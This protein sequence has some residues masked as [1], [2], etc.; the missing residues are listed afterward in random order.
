MGSRRAQVKLGLA[1]ALLLPVPVLAEVCDPDR[2]DLR[3]AFGSA[4]FRVE[5]ADDAAERAQGLMFREAM[6]AGAGMLFVYDSPQRPYFWMKNTLIPL[7][8]I[9]VDETGVVTRVHEN[10]VPHDETP[11]DGGPDVRFVLE[12]NGGLAA[13][14]GIAPGDQLR[15]PTITAGV[16]SCAVE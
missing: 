5:V 3:G 9:F 13:R 7:D 6:A 11:I 10:A 8:M 14:L 2:V 15:H 16:W 1:L 12:I 4:R